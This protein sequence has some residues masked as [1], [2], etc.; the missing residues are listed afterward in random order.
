MKNNIAIICT[1]LACVLFFSSCGSERVF[2]EADSTNASSKTTTAIPE[3]TS[4]VLSPDKFTFSKIQ[5][6]MSIDDTQLAIGQAST[7]LA[8]EQK[9]KYFFTNSFKGIAGIDKDIEKL[10]YFIFNASA[11]LEEIQYV[12]NHDDGITY[13]DMVKLFK[14]QFGKYVEITSEIGKEECIW[15]HK[16]VYV[17]VTDNGNKEIVISYFEETFFETEYKYELELYKKGQ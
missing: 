15:K 13:E 12:V 8:N 5:M 3:T 11:K 6:G 16:D 10:V 17:I 7:I 2:E 14:T 9:Q 4:Y 1:L